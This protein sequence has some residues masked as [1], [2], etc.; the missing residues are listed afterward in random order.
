[1]VSE[2]TLVHRQERSKLIL[3]VILGYSVRVLDYAIHLGPHSPIRV[4]SSSAH[5]RPVNEL[6]LTFL[7]SSHRCNPL[8]LNTHPPPFEACTS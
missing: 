8:H 5:L 6:R 1:M 3:Q 4:R 7:V 2:L